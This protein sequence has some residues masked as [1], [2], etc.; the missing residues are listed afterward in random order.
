MLQTIIVYAII[1]LSIAYSVFAVL[2]NI[3][4]KDTSGC[5]DCNGCDIKREI[6][7]NL[8]KPAGRNPETCGHAVKNI[9]SKAKQMYR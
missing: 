7:K 2:K 9:Q 5:G 3:R 4:A 8:Q 6:T 1:L